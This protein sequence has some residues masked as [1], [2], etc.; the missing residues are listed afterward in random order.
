MA[1]QW[2]ETA[3]A[4]AGADKATTGLVEKFVLPRA[5]RQALLVTVQKYATR[6]ARIADVLAEV[7]T[8]CLIPTKSQVG[9]SD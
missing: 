6:G 5:S 7:S 1:A 2:R 9:I 3:V 4:L 8:D